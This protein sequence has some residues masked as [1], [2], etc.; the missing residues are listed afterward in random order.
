MTRIVSEH[1]DSGLEAVSLERLAAGNS[2]EIWAVTARDARGGERSLILRR[3]AAAGVLSW[4]DRKHEYRVLHALEGCG[5]PVPLAYGSGELERPYVLMERRPGKAP[6][7]S[8]DEVDARALGRELGEMLARLHALSPLALGFNA[9]QTTRDYTLAA[10]RFWRERYLGGRPCPVP[11]LGALIAWAER[12][13]PDD[14]VPPAL[15]WGDPGPHNCLVEDGA[16][17]G[18]LDWELAHVG[19]PLEDLG[20][21]VWACLGVLNPTELVAAYETRS[22]PIDR[23]TLDYFVVFANVTRSVMLLDGVAAWIDG[24]ITQPSTAGLGLELLAVNLARG[25]EAAGWGTLPPPDGRPPEFPL[26]PDVSESAAGVARWLL[27]DLVP[28]IDERPRL[29]RMVKAAA[30]LLEVAACRVPSVPA[31]A[32]DA[33][34][35]E[36]VASE[37][38]GGDASLRTALLTDL[39]RE[40]ARLTPL[41]V[42]HG[43]PL[44]ATA[45]A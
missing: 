36:A 30:A 26:R 45:G 28:A 32:L 5:L 42:L 1:V 35:E 2:Q 44:L 17:S 38:A 7:R 12:N 8:A 14:G 18:L 27:S 21:A 10:V 4:T 22:G 9:S 41:T 11:L 19:H 33:A 15:L 34:E 37:L 31:R 3:S 24:R 39:S 13:V 16:I 43:H 25:A 29:R 23:V 40:L 6:S 20:A